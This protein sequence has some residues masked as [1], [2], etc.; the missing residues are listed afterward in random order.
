VLIQQN[1]DGEETP[2]LC[3]LCKGRKTVSSD[4]LIAE[5]RDFGDD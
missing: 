5:N 3:P 2:Y 1:E 4:N